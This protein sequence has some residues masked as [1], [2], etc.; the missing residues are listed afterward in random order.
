MAKPKSSAKASAGW[1][2]KKAIIIIGISM[3][4]AIF[5]TQ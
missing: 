4:V 2:N 3:I 5:A 1:R